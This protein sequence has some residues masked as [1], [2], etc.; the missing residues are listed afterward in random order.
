V[1]RLLLIGGVVTLLMSGCAGVGGK[2]CHPTKN[3]TEFE[4]D[5]YECENIAM[6]KAHNFGA[7]GNPFIIFDDMSR[8]MRIK[9]GWYKCN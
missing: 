3:A 9:Y 8:C 1:K 5:K 7:S 6:A 2:W 4:Q